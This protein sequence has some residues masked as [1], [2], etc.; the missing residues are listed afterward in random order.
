MEH[1]QVVPKE[2]VRLQCV[3]QIVRIL[4]EI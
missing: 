4:I 1:H 2:P 3:E